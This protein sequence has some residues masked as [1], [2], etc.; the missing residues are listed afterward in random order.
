MNNNK[1]INDNPLSRR[2][3]KRY[4]KQPSDIKKRLDELYNQSSI[5]YQLNVIKRKRI[6]PKKGD[7]FLV[8]PID[9]LY[10]FGVVI[11]DNVSNK[12]G[13]GLYVVMIFRNKAETL[14]DTNFVVEYNNL[15][16][17]PSI[18]G[19]EYWTKGYFYNIAGRVE[20]SNDI[21]YGFYSIGKGKYV[22]E[23]G[24]EIFIEPYLLGTFGVSTI[25][26][27]AYEINKELIIDKSLLE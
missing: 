3:K 27:I 17:K 10:F 12:N 7:V 25:D 8:N 5:Q 14:I 6:I 15:L 9:S 4:D 16:I 2:W 13:D 19:K 22:D 26:G 24:N 1:N 11:N 18:V 21:S 23:Y 20:P